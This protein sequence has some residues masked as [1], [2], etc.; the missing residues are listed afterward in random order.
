M[1]L[2]DNFGINVSLKFC[3][4]IDLWVNK[5]ERLGVGW[6]RLELD[7]FSPEFAKYDEFIAQADKKGIRM[8]GCV[9]G[10]VPGKLHYF[11][12]NHRYK[13]PYRHLQAYLD[14]LEKCCSRYPQIRHWEVYNEPNI[15]RFWIDEPDPKEYFEML[16]RGSRIIRSYGGK[17]ICAG[18][19][20]N[21]DEATP[22]VRQY[23]IRDLL[24][25]GARK[26][27]DLLSVH[28]Y[29]LESYL[30]ISKKQHF[31][32]HFK[33]ELDHCL[34]KYGNDF[35]VTEWGIS[36]A[37]NLAM[38]EEDVGIVYLKALRYAASKGIKLFFWHFNDFDMPGI[39]FAE[40][41][42]GLVKEDLMEKGSF[43]ILKRA[44]SHDPPQGRTDP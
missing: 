8:L 38:S 41:S 2:K 10:F 9:F 36:D 32:S 30:G 31:L 15:K 11:L 24:D 16:V 22:F 27:I 37:A 39:F 23:F 40:K 20:M 14:F 17:V 19:A 43:K 28:P 44:R 25:M 18:T 12:F 13:S 6:V 26:H 5:L 42:F 35:W 34:N 29:S 7:W 21:D 4:S 33:K 1:V 3:K